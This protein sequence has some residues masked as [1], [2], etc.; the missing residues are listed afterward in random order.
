MGR[1]QR[2]LRRLLCCIHVA[3]TW[4]VGVTGA[5][6]RWAT[7]PSTRLGAMAAPRRSRSKVSAG[8]GTSQV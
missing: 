4:T 7:V 8:P 6:V 3:V 2:P 5:L 1:W